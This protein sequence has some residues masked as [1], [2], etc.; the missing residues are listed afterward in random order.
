MRNDDNTNSWTV[1]HRI[2]SNTKRREGAEEGNPDQTGTK[3]KPNQTTTT[4]E[5]TPFS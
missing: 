4:I 2:D 1:N 3:A 5:L